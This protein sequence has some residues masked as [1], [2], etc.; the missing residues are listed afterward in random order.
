M[1]QSVKLAFGYVLRSRPYRNTSALVDVFSRDYGRLTLVA[2]G[3]RA[4]KSPWS[5]W[6]QPFQLLRL[7]WQGQRDLKNLTHVE[8]TL[9]G[10]W[11]QGLTLYSGLYLNELLLKFLQPH[12]AHAQLFDAYHQALK[13]L[14]QPELLEAVLRQFEMA[15]LCE[16]GYGLPVADLFAMPIEALLHYGFDAEH[17]W[18]PFT[19]QGVVVS[20]QTLLDMREQNYQRL[21]T[22]QEA[23]R[24]MRY[25]IDLHLGGQ[26]LHTRR[27]LQTTANLQ[28]S[29]P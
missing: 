23:K 21:S 20:G 6:L 25:L 14:A 24:L 10:C 1:Q 26:P 7:S 4:S 13:S 22:R 17:G 12:D 18:V 8:N 5:S 15:L 2:K 3:V 27:L 29:V 9:G 19:R 28:V 16:S 11:L